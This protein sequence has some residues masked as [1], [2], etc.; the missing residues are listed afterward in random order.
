MNKRFAITAARRRARFRKT[1]DWDEEL[2]WLP[3]P[4]EA[5]RRMDSRPGFL[6]RYTAEQ[7][8]ELFSGALD[9]DL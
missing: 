8:K 5:R 1:I 2:R 6:D 7:V 4:E 3:T 9:P